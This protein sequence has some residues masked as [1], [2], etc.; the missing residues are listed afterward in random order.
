[1]PCNAIGTFSGTGNNRFVNIITRADDNDVL[2]GA[3]G[4]RVIE[5]VA[6]RALDVLKAEMV[7]R[8]RQVAP[9]RSSTPVDFNGDQRSPETPASRAGNVT[10]T[11]NGNSTRWGIGRA[12]TRQVSQDTAMSLKDFEETRSMAAFA[13]FFLFSFTVAA[14][15]DVVFFLSGSWISSLGFSGLWVMSV[16]VGAACSVHR[17]SLLALLWPFCLIVCR[18]SFPSSG[19]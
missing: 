12:S 13:I 9:S 3:V 2:D 1:M 5:T 11:G 4:V 6:V 15:A 17:L 8:A 7:I 19:G 16:I 14:C 10:K 18:S